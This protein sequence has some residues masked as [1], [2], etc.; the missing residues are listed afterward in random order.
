MSKAIAK[1]TMDDKSNIKDEDF[2][3]HVFQT[4]KMTF[5]G[6]IG[7]IEMDEEI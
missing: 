3:A 2:E 1:T 5:D 6:I 4:F 7:G